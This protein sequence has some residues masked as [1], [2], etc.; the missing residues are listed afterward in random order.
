ML[1]GQVGILGELSVHFSRR[2]YYTRCVYRHFH[3]STVDATLNRESVD[4]VATGEE[5]IVMGAGGS[6]TEGEKIAPMD[7]IALIRMYNREKHN[8]EAMYEELLRAHPGQESLRVKSTP[9]LRVPLVGLAE[10][11]RDYC[12]FGREI[13]CDVQHVG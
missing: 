11:H 7:E 9:S 4:R 3:N 5:G 10:R 6:I 2:Y 1:G 12:C 13:V 8:E